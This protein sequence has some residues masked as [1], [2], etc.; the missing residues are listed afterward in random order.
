MLK[1]IHH[2][3][4]I[5]IIILQDYNKGL[6]SQEM[7][8][9]VIKWS[10]DNHVKTALD[11][12]QQNIDFFKG[13]DI[14]KPNLKEL[15]N[16]IGQEINIERKS[17]SDACYNVLQRME[18][19]M[20]LLT[21][22]ADGVYV[23]TE[24]SSHWESTSVQSIVDVS[25]AGDTVI[26]IV[27]LLYANGEASLTEIGKLAN[28]GGAAVCKIPGVGVVNKSMIVGVVEKMK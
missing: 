1:F 5:D 22:S 26:S 16:F 12:K 18:C 14:F 4:N 7:I 9:M 19:D 25:G 21:L 23:A 20:V 28:Y 15:R 3:Q 13:V 17:L 11:P 2:E 10:K 24:D 27:S 6:F 8:K